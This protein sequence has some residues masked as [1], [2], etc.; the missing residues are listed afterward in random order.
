M[1][2]QAL[3]DHHEC[4]TDIIS[5]WSGRVHDIRIFRN[6]GSVNNLTGRSF[7]PWTIQLTL[8]RFLCWS[9]FCMTLLIFCF[10]G[11][12]THILASWTKA[13]K[14]LTITYCTLAEGMECAFWKLKGR[15]KCL[16]EKLDLNKDTILTIIAACQYC[17]YILKASWESWLAEWD[18][19]QT[20]LAAEFEQPESSMLTTDTASAFQVRDA[21]NSER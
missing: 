15:W 13:R 2:I 21:L 3:V 8:T 9:W 11:S 4:F 17:I 18:T 5:G 19:C 20:R 6:S 14:G 12:L 16:M 10:P 7:F 1:V